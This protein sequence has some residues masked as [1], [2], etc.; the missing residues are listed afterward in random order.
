M[1]SF[2]LI[3]SLR[4]SLNELLNKTQ[5]NHT[6][7]ERK[8]TSI[9]Q[10]T[11]HPDDLKNDT[12]VG[13]F[14]ANKRYLTQEEIIKGLNHIFNTDHAVVV[15]VVQMVLP[16]RFFTDMINRNQDDITD[17]LLHKVTDASPIR[18]VIVPIST[19]GAGEN[20]I[21]HYVI[22]FFDILERKCVLVDSLSRPNTVDMTTYT[23]YISYD[24]PNALPEYHFHFLST[25]IQKDGFQCG[26][27]LLE[28]ARLFADQ[29]PETTSLDIFNP[30]NYT[31]Y[32][33]NNKI[34][35]TAARKKWSDIIY[36]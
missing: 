8:Y 11:Y 14:V 35:I 1:N 9:V 33:N 25:G 16:Y 7:V 30:F 29:N 10:P 2:S 36:R 23:D 13:Q 20:C 6:N 21:S 34:N 5:V 19:V 15:V 26:I 27:Y 12:I 17:L 18:F 24:F 22:M 4:F 32:L 31:E 28:F 3:E